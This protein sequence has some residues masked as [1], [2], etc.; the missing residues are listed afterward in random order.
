MS[1]HNTVRSQAQ[2]SFGIS[3]ARKY[4]YTGPQGDFNSENNFNNTFNNNF[5]SSS[6]SIYN[7]QLDWNGLVDNVFKE[8]INKL[9]HGYQ[10]GQF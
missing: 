1:S 2:Q 8:E 9:A 6:S 10:S 5:N 4:N 7:N 3:E